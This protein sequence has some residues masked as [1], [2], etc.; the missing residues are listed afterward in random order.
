[1][2]RARID[3]DE[4]PEGAPLYMVTFADLMGQ[5]VCFFLIL[6]SMS[7]VRDEK[8]RKMM[9]SIR[10][11]FGYEMGNEVTPGDAK[12]TSSPW[13]GL[14]VVSTPRGHKNVQ[15]GS[16]VVNVN[17]REFL[18]R[19]VRDGRQVTLGDPVGFET[20]A[21]SIPASMREDLDALAG[22]VKDYPNRLIVSGHV[23]AKE[24]AGA[25]AEMDLSFRRAKAVG[26]YFEQHGI[27]PKRLRLAASGASDPVD[28]NLTD[29]GRA[30]NR[31]VEITVSEE[32]VTNAIPR[33]PDHD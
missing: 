29:E 25:E 30:R 8:F 10:Q 20:G 13:D 4:K 7:T 12:R 31:R 18:C 5:L 32:L 3:I 9:D 15:G 19:T 23:S 21:A 33:R 1:M 14:A 16:E 11:A 2:S 17:G 6:V 28:T 26:D 27:N 22:L 24:T